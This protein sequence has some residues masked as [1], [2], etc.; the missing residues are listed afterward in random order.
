MKKT[1]NMRGMEKKYKNKKIICEKSYSTFLVHFRVLLIIM[2]KTRNM[3]M[4]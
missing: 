4:R 1:K 3:K 2:N